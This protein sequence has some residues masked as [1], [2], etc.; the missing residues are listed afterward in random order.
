MTS[1]YF[2]RGGEKSEPIKRQHSPPPAAI[3]TRAQVPIFGAPTPTVPTVPTVPT[4]RTDRE[5][6]TNI[7]RAQ[8]EAIRERIIRW[9]G[10]VLR[11]HD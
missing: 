10:G 3:I 6:S 4:W 8:N 2:L 7:G 9:R 5:A 1:D 11:Q